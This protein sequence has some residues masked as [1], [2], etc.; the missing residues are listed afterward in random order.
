MSTRGNRRRSF[1]GLPNRKRFMLTE[2]QSANRKHARTK[3]SLEQYT[4]VRPSGQ[5]A[6]ARS[7]GVKVGPVLDEA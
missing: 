2:A 1:A 5:R 4:E 7:S 3:W 6:L